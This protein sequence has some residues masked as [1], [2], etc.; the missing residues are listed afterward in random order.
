MLLVNAERTHV[1]WRIVHKPMTNHLILPLESF[2][3]YSA[4]TTRN[5][6]K[7][8]AILGVNIGVRAVDELVG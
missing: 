2:A 7:M 3:S 5:G 4:R 8:W 1:S 6:T